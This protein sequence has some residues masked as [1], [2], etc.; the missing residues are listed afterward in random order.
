M[1]TSLTS[2]QYYMRLAKRQSTRYLSDCVLHPTKYMTKF[3][4]AILKIVLR[5]RKLK[6]SMI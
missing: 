1:K 5:D 3:H 2:H 6:G 4:V